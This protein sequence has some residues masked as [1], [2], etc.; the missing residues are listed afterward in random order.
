MKR[1]VVSS[2]SLFRLAGNLRTCIC[3]IICMMKKF[4]LTS[5]ANLCMAGC[6]I[7]VIAAIVF[8]VFTS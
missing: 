6:I 8:M 1:Y 5:V 7:A 3:S 2:N 4:E